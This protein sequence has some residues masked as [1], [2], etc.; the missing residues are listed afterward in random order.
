MSE[1]STELGLVLG[2]AALGSVG[3][4]VYRQAVPAALPANLLSEATSAVHDSVEAA[5]AATEHLPFGQ[6]EAVLAPLGRRST[7]LP[8]SVQLLPWPWPSSPCGAPPTDTGRGTH[9]AETETAEVLGQAGDRPVEPS[10]GH[11]RPR[12]SHT[13]QPTENRGQSLLGITQRPRWP[14]PTPASHP[15][16]P[17]RLPFGTKSSRPR[18][19]EQDGAGASIRDRFVRRMSSRADRASQR[20]DV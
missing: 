4:V 18:G 14:W 10:M 15:I 13:A 7:S 17:P 12:C 3:A 11:H 20:L 1:T 2:V 6:A 9:P 8:G 19:S 5:V 16:R